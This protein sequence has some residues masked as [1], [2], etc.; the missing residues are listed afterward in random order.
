[1]E[2][3]IDCEGRPTREVNG[4]LKRLAAEGAERIRVLNPGARHCLGVARLPPRARDVRGLGRLPLR[5][6]RRRRATT[7][8]RARRAGRSA[9]TCCPARCSCTAARAPTSAAPRSAARSSSRARVGTRAGIANKGATIV[10]GGDCGYMSAFMM[11]LGTLVVCGDADDGL[12]DS[13]YAGDIFLGGDLVGAR[14]RLRRAG[15]HRRRPRHASRALCDAA[16]PR[17]APGVAQVRLG[18]QAAQLRQARVRDLA[19]GDVSELPLH[20]PDDA[21]DHVPP[22]RFVPHHHAVWEPHVIEDIQLKAELGR[23]RYRGMSTTRPGAELRRPHVPAVH[24]LARAA[25]GLPRALRDAHGARHALRREARSSC[26]SPSRSA[27]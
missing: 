18:R 2:P 22:R 23:Y 14:R 21:R 10:I 25:G 8:S 5:H 12:G 6:A 4:E 27:A 16:R 7:R 15:A 19:G 11:Q 3:V 13:M 9:P 24:P 26:R 17:P 1:M 20:D